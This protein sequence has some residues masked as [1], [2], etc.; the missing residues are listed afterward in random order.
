M[1]Y[2]VT[3]WVGLPQRNVLLALRPADLGLGRGDKSVGSQLR[4]WENQDP[5]G[6]VPPRRGSGLWDKG[7]SF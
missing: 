7:L 1:L 5:L 2:H 3:H 6:S 4:R